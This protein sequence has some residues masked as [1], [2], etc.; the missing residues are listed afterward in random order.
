MTMNSKA[1]D[2]VQARQACVAGSDILYDAAHIKQPEAWFFEAGH[3]REK[4][5]VLS[6][7]QG[8]GA[9]CIF[10]YQGHD[11]VLRHYR[12]G[13]LMARFSDDKYAWSGL[14]K[15]RAWR[16]WHLLAKMFQQGLPVPRPVAARVQRLGL[17][18]RADLVT[19]RLPDVQPL[20]DV[21]MVRKLDE[22]AWRKL[23]ATIRRFHDA[24]IYH[25][26]L[27]ARNILLDARG[28]VFVI[29]F[30]KGEER[31]PDKV[32]QQAN[33]D[34]LERSFNKFNDNQA[35]FYFDAQAM[36]WLLEGYGSLL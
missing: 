24:G 16:E 36:A 34:R 11:Y 12:R 9:A 5:A 25:A 1:G 7:A 33:I 14:E 10:H 15:T 18:Y 23:G 4:G 30:D 28:Q 22:K 3:W 6:T 27:N 17:F 8:R 35:C 13:G 2:D 21:L 19:L 26:D 20:A 29:D 32:W 31:R